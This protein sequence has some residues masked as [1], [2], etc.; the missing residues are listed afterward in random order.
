MKIYLPIISP[1]YAL[2]SSKLV[3]GMLAHSPSSL[4]SSPSANG[5]TK[6]REEVI[7][8]TKGY[9]L[10]LSSVKYSLSPARPL[11]SFIHK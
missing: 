10:A 7:L 11:N 4:H 5:G 8:A 3:L 1:F 9:S 6:K 2:V